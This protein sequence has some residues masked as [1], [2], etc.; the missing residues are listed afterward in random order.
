LELMQWSYDPRDNLLPP[1][2]VDLVLCVRDE[3][4]V[5]LDTTART[6]HSGTSSV[7][8]TNREATR[9]YSGGNR[10]DDEVR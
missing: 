8:Q 6:R 2:I 4:S 5:Q 1:R 10:D 3:G 7:V 9:D